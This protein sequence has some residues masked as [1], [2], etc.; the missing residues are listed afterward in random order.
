[1]DL[2]KVTKASSVSLLTLSMAAALVGCS[3][4]S[5]SSNTYTG[6]AEGKN[7][8]VTVEV[9]YADGKIESVTVTE[10]Q[11]TEGIA[12]P[13]LEQIPAAIVEAQTPNV[14][15]V[16][17]ATITSEAIIN[18]TKAALESA[19]VDV[20]SLGEAAG[21]ENVEVTYTAGTYE[22]T[23][24]G[25]NGDVTLSVTF[26]K[27]SIEDI[28]VVESSETA[29]VGTVAYDII[30]DDAKEANGSGVDVVSGATFTSKA[31]KDALAD[32]AAKA[33]ASDLDGFKSNTVVHE[34]QDPIEEEYDVVVVGAGGAG[35][36]AAAQA[37]QNGY[38]VLVM[39]ENAEIGGNTLV[40]G[41]QFQSVMP[42]L[43]WD[44]EDPDATTGTWDY[45]GESMGTPL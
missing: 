42:Y 4:N 37:A 15:T 6:T 2:K 43:V 24:S 18:A 31:L 45:N 19:G 11:E 38:S 29:H 17:G 20:D 12:D 14:D 13:A 25:Y 40:S 5:G 1:M 44:E 33:E 39:E 16:S 21:H 30:F 8:D 28:E 41:G 35:M 10:Q 36:G 22:G 26:G 32:A 9:V 23:G 27:D 34:A 7:G 3:S